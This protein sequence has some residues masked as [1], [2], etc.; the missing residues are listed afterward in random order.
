MRSQS[1]L[2]Q[3]GHLEYKEEVGKAFQI[4]VECRDTAINATHP[5]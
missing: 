4:S 3:S 2:A 5:R 1:E